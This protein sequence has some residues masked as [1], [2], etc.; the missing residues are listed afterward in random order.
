MDLEC[1][2]RPKDCKGQPAWADLSGF[3]SEQGQVCFLFGEVKS[4]RDPSSPP[5]VLYG[6]S[7]LNDQLERLCAAKDHWSLIKWL[8]SRC[9]TEQDV[10]LYREALHRYI[11]TR[12]LGVLIVGCLVR[13]APVAEVRYRRA[14]AS[15]SAS[16]S[17]AHACRPPRL[18]PANRDARMADADRGRRMMSSGPLLSFW[19]S[20]FTNALTRTRIAC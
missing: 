11:D 18:V 8:R 7:G 16:R 10:V 4:S 6:R 14:S 13:D 1:F 12:K 5:N 20:T 9:T 15:L 3:V 2:A 17:S 19:I